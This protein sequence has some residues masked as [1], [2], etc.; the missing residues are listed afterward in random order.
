VLSAQSQSAAQLQ[1]QLGTAIII[2]GTTIITMV[3]TIIPTITGITTPITPTIIIIIIF[4]T[5]GTTS[6]KF[7]QHDTACVLYFADLGL[8]STGEE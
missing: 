8:R 6:A 2:I 3:T 4:I 7:F 1:R 5:T